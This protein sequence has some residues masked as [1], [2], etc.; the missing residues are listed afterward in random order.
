[1]SEIDKNSDEFKQAVADAVAAEVEGL[2][3]KNAE[4]IAK[5]KKLQAGATIDPA[6]YAALEAER[7]QFKQQAID[8][9]KAAAKAQ[10][11]AEA[12]AKRAADTDAAFNRTLTEAA[13]TEQLTK[14]GVTNAVH[15]KAAKALLASGLQVVDEN[16]TRVV[17]AGDVALDKHI[18]DWAGSDEGKHF[19]TARDTNGGGAQGGGRGGNG[20][21]PIKEWSD[22][23]K[24]G[25]IRENGLEAFK[26]LV[27]GG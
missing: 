20:A 14:A 21:K 12:A 8:A 3:A 23:E 17:K 18:T 16:G 25:F 9:Q 5:N 15:L 19:V 4:L 11:D 2:K 27:H 24:A 26:Q 22:A 7:D 13:L 1:M 6:D 10:K